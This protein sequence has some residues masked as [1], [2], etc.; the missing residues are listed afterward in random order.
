M[1][2]EESDQGRI[3]A[4]TPSPKHW[5]LKGELQ[6]PW[7]DTAQMWPMGSKNGAVSWQKVRNPFMEI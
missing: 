6:I 3:C 1:A 7:G 2:D 5:F 4:H